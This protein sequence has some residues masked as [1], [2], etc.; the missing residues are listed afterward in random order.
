[1]TGNKA[2]SDE[3]ALAR[4]NRPD[5]G[6]GEIDRQG[7]CRECS[8]RPLPQT[9]PRADDQGDPAPPGPVRAR[10]AAPEAARVRPEPW[11]GL[12][13][14][15]ARI[16][17]AAPPE[18]EPA[19]TA[20]TEERRFCANPDCGRPVGRGQDDRPGRV[21]GYCPKCGQR[22][23]FTWTLPGGIVADRYEVRGGSAAAAPA[24]HC[25]PT[26]AAS[27]RMWC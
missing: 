3:S 10:P 15:T 21:R 11:W 14:V 1:M 27:A 7:F 22:F 18:P 20:V 6:L 2:A 17:P 24:P 12:D 5:C 25:W 13:L 23:D 8:R 26:T 4:C 9:A 16:A 19:S